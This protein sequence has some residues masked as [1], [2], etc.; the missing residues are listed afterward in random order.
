MLP[1]ERAEKDE[2]LIL[3]AGLD[4]VGAHPI[5]SDGVGFVI[6]QDGWGGEAHLVIQIQIQNHLDKAHVGG[7][8][9]CRYLYRRDLAPKRHR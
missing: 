7:A 5:D 9:T 4:A 6:E 2:A 1:I 3:V 8:R